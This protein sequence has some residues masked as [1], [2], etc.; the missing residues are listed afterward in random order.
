MVDMVGVGTCT[1][2]LGSVCL[3][4]DDVLMEMDHLIL[5][6]YRVHPDSTFPARFGGQVPFQDAPVR[7][8]SPVPDLP[9]AQGFASQAVPV[10]DVGD[11]SGYSNISRSSYEM[12]EK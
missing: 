9:I 10:A 5:A 7:V 1:A 3:G 11:L 8:A 12:L 2:S 4:D 6:E